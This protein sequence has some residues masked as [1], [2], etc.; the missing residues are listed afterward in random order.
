MKRASSAARD[1]SYRHQRLRKALLASWGN[2]PCSRCLSPF[3]PEDWA[4][5]RDRI[6][7]DHTDDRSGYRGLSHADCNTRKVNPGSIPSPKARP[8]TQ[9]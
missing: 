9:W 5:P 1:Y 7:L 6:H 3:T 4:N 2:R 8:A